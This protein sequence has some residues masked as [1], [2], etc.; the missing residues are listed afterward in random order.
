[1]CDA[2]TVKDFLFPFVVEGLKTVKSFHVNP[3]EKVQ[4]GNSQ[5]ELLRFVVWIIPEGALYGRGEG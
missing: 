3:E 2:S 5:W 4:I 1:M